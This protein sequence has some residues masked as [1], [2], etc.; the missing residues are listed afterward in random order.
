MCAIWGQVHEGVQSPSIVLLLQE[1]MR[2]YQFDERI[3]RQFGS[4]QVWV[5]LSYPNL[6]ITNTFLLS[7]S[8]NSSSSST[9]EC[10]L[11]NN[12]PSI[13]SVVSYIKLTAAKHAHRF[14]A[15]AHERILLKGQQHMHPS[16]HIWKANRLEFHLDIMET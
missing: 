10:S 4:K 5:L 1:M 11:T 9:T 2:K 14:V 12:A 13:R 6:L 8:D 15:E 16:T 7:N 3:R